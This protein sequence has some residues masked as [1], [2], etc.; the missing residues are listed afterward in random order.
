MYKDSTL[1]PLCWEQTSEKNYE[2]HFLKFHKQKNIKNFKLFH[3]KRLNNGSYLCPDCLEQFSK[4]KKLKKHYDS[5]HPAGFIKAFDNHKLE[6]KEQKILKDIENKLN[7]NESIECFMCN[8]YY[9]SSEL[10]NHFLE[11][12]N[13]SITYKDVLLG[14]KVKAFIKNNSEIIPNYVKK[15]SSDNVNCPCCYES[16]SVSEYESHFLKNHED[17][18]KTRLSNFIDKSFIKYLGL[19]C[20]SFKN[21]KISHDTMYYSGTLLLKTGVKIPQFHCYTCNKNYISSEDIQKDELKLS[22]GKIFYNIKNLLSNEYQNCKQTNISCS[23]K[24]TISN[25]NENVIETLAKK[26]E[27]KDQTLI[28]KE[29]NVLNL[30]KQ[31]QIV[32]KIERSDIFT[33]DEL[34][35]LIELYVKE[36]P[37]NT[38]NRTT[39]INACIEMADDGKYFFIDDSSG[40]ILLIRAKTRSE[41]QRLG[42]GSVYIPYVKVN[43]KKIELSKFILYVYDSY[44]NVKCVNSTKHKEENITV[45]TDGSNGYPVSFSAN[46]CSVCNKYYTTK[47]S[48]DRDFPSKNYPFIHMALCG[49]S[50]SF[51]NQESELHYYG[52]SVKADGMSDKD[53]QNLLARLITFGFLSKSKIQNI[54]TYFINYNGK[55]KNM[56]EAV[57]KWKN[58]LEF[59]TEY[60]IDKQR[61]IYVENIKSI[62]HGR[63]Y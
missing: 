36:P 33:I 28:L 43:D 44:N 29:K 13:S 6:T 55:R 20:P 32:V 37:A 23:T 12:H 4:L 48:I 60:N 30:T 62:Y 8:T 10:N 9:T 35:R 34:N 49:S 52:Y 38:I 40:Q 61:K 45:I 14:K 53:R 25:L 19:T 5:L 51:L 15:I 2:K 26:H 50:P 18:Y 39:L 42:L 24:I 11:K 46:Y 59:V 63:S 7:S 54:I 27:Q 17:L 16:L 21:G 3:V 22:N 58:D 1:C 47:N 41:W 56:S 31:I 57:S